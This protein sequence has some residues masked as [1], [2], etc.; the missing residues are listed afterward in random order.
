M[1]HYLDILTEGDS[2]IKFKIDNKLYEIKNDKIKAI[3][4]F[5]SYARK[6]Y[7]KYSD[8]DIFIMVSDCNP[9]EYRILKNDFSKQ[10]KVPIDWISV[11]QKSKIYE[12]IKYG[13]Y[14]LWHLKIEGVKLY[15]EDDILK[16]SFNSLQ[17][18]KNVRRDI[19]E[20]EMIYEDIVISLSRDL[21]VIEYELNL[22][23]SIIRNTSIAIAHM[24]NRYLFDR[25]EPVKYCIAKWPQNIKFNLEEYKEL[26]FFRIKYNRKNINMNEKDNILEYSRIWIRHTKDILSLGKKILINR[27]EYYETFK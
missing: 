27:G 10:L 14:F 13:S 3:Y 16:K 15:D 19:E 17:K 21:L 4:L 8:I 2:I 6:D 7:D 25:Y 22:M 11:Y 9:E 12:M 1:Q 18:Y 5:G 23:A 26:Y 24:E 20:Y